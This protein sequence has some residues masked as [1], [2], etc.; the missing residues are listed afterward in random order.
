MLHFSHLHLV[1]CEISRTSNT[2]CHDKFEFFTR[3]KIYVRCSFKYKLVSLR[4]EW[5]LPWYGWTVSVHPAKMEKELPVNGVELHAEDAAR[6]ILVT[7]KGT[8][9]RI[10]IRQNI[11][12]QIC[13]KMK[14]ETNEG[15]CHGNRRNL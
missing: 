14:E 3:S 10:S 2:I 6:R 5:F 8:D 15:D 4:A 13:A 1:R 9:E 7:C 12:T 11:K